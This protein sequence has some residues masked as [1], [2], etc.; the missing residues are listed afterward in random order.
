MIYGKNQ[1]S[2]QLK[3]GAPKINE[4]AADGPSVIETQNTTDIAHKNRS[5]ENFFLQFLTLMN[6]DLYGVCY[7]DVPEGSVFFNF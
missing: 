2:N 1:Q 6:P 7:F 5:E 4:I 3:L